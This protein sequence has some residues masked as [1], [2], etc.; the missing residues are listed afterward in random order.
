[1]DL[2]REQLLQRY[3]V[4]ELTTNNLTIFTS[5]DLRLQETAQRILES[6]LA[7]IDG[8]LAKTADGREVQGR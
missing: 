4:E 1:V 8:R 5:L 6:G 2:L 7:R 3:S